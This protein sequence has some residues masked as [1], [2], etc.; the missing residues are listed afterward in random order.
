[1]TQ[2]GAL[3]LAFDGGAQ[4]GS[5]ARAEIVK[6]WQAAAFV[7]GELWGRVG[8]DEVAL[9]NGVLNIRTGDLRPHDPLDYLD[10]VI[11]HDYDPTASCDFWM[12]CLERYFGDLT[13]DR[14]AALQEY[15]GY[16]LTSHAKYKKALFLYGPSGT[17]KS[18][19]VEALTALV[20]R[21]YVCTI[22]LELLD[23]PKRVSMIKGKSLNVV[24]ELPDGALIKDGAFKALVSTEEPILLDEKYKRVETYTPTAKH[25]I[26]TNTLP[27]IADRSDATFARLL[28]VHMDRPVP[29][30]DTR[31][32]LEIDER[33]A[34]ES[35]GIINWALD[36]LRRLYVG[37]GVFTEPGSSREL[38]QGYRLE[39]NPLEQFISERCRRVP[40]GAGAK[41]RRG[42][43]TDR[44][45]AEFNAWHR[46]GRAWS[47]TR[48]TRT[49][50]TMALDGIEVTNAKWHGVSVRTVVG[51][52]LVPV[53]ELPDVL[54]VDADGDGHEIV[55]PA[56]DEREARGPEP[57]PAADE[58]AV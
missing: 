24:T 26:A 40:G 12:E 50:N 42:V 51:L 36:G 53:G 14:V 56:D 58:R 6:Y 28:I 20:G 37:Q 45:L 15:A 3:A 33:I 16:I 35:S 47:K 4:G 2:H 54:E 39:Q 49:L 1:M 22:P 41:R 46:G 38:I 10:H 29:K 57:T 48:L 18:R 27:A 32:A 17:G 7:P 52:E 11:P 21:K 23:D 9:G 34:A 30:G 44:L 8:M 25:V 13:D 5:N 55:E 43:T 31:A 19:I